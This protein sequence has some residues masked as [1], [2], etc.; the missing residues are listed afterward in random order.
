MLF[1]DLRDSNAWQ[2]CMPWLTF[3]LSVHRHQ[4]NSRCQV[5]LVPVCPWGWKVPV[6]QTQRWDWGAPPSGR[7]VA[8]T[9]TPLWLSS[10]KL[11]VRYV[12]KHV[13]Q[14]IL[15]KLIFLMLQ[16][17]T[18]TKLYM[19]FLAQCTNPSRRAW[20]PAVYYPVPALQ[21]SEKGQGH[22]PRQEVSLLIVIYSDILALF[23]SLDCCKIKYYEFLPLTV[24]QMP[25][26]TS[27][28]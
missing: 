9:P 26:Q 8:S 10:L 12:D 1:I 5:P 25:A 15:Q 13:S 19:L 11:S 18:C 28:T 27:S 17:M 20:I 4:G 3:L 14:I 22:D 23:L 2:H 24:G 6:C 21:W 16:R 7:C